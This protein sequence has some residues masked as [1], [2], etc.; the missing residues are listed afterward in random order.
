LGETISV[1]THFSEHGRRKH[2]THAG[3]AQ[4]E[5]RIRMTLQKF[6]DGAFKRFQLPIQELELLDQGER[7]PS[8]ASCRTGRGCE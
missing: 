4:E 2:N 6:A 3:E 1:F 7:S 5:V 8:L